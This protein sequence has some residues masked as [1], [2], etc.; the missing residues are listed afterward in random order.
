MTLA[1]APELSVVICTHNRA[2]DLRAALDSLSRQ[3]LEAQRFEIIVVDNDS[4][5]DTRAVVEGASIN[6]K[7]RYIFEGTLG[8]CNARNTGWNAARAD[9]V[10]YLDDDALAYPD[11]AIELLSAFERASPE[12][13]CVGGRICPLYHVPRPEWL[14]DDVALSLTIVDWPG[15][16]HVITDL[17]SEWLAGA[18]MAIRRSVLNAVGGFHPALD[19][20]GIRMLSSGDVFLQQEIINAGYD[21]LY[22][23][24]AR[25]DH[26][27]PASRLRRRWFTRRFYWQGESDAV[28]EILRL[29]LTRREARARALRRA[30]TLMIS[31]RQ[32]CH[33]MIPTRNP[34]RFA[35]QCWAWIALGHII[36]L[37]RGR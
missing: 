29:G 31:P 6:P 30:G 13:G 23:P 36:G 26:Q 27:V 25:V 3:R 35:R 21:C 2:Q 28:M 24:S 11:W 8:L 22:E 15:G 14:G 10:A 7:P 9:I 17:R 20:S 33:L 1:P 16:A 4:G 34:G 12:T 18:N 37:V 5:D 32:L 19:R